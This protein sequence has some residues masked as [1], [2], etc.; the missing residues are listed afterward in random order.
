MSTAL[1]NVESHDQLVRRARSHIKQFERKLLGTP[2]SDAD[3]G[4]R[5]E[6]QDIIVGA[7]EIA[8]R[9]LTSENGT[10]L[11]TDY[12]STPSE[13]GRRTSTGAW[14]LGFG[15]IKRGEG[16]GRL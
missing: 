13:A 11:N 6:Q 8:A 2:L 14:Q 12:R 4:E 10:F 9:Q 16:R 15:I 1:E 3:G 5:Q 7:F